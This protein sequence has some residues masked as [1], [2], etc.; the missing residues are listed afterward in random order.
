MNKKRQR[1]EIGGD[2]G[3]EEWGGYMNAKKSKLHGQFLEQ[4]KKQGQEHS[5]TTDIFKGVSVFVNG[6]TV[7]SADE[8]KRIMMVNGG[9]YHHYFSTQHTTHIIAS[10]LPDVKIKQLKNLHINIVKPEW[11]TA[12][13]NASLQVD[14]RPYLLY[15]HQSKTQPSIRSFAGPA[16]ST[17]TSKDHEL[18]IELGGH[19]TVQQ[20]E[21]SAMLENSNCKADDAGYDSEDLF[22]SPE[23][24]RANKSTVT[25]LSERDPKA[26]SSDSRANK[27]TETELSERDPK[28]ETSKSN[29]NARCAT[30]PN[31]L[32]EFYNN[33][34]LHHISTMGAMFKQFVLELRQK[35]SEFSG[36]KRLRDWKKTNSCRKPTTFEEE[37]DFEDCLEDN[38]FKPAA[39]V[40]GKIIMH[41]DMDCFFVSVGLRRY[42]HLKGKPVAVTHSKGNGAI[43][44]TGSDRKSEF[45][46][47]KER[48][49]SKLKNK[50][51]LDDDGALQ[52]RVAWMNGIDEN[53]SMAEIA[54]CSYEARQKGLKNGMFVGAAL[55]L[56]PDLKV[57]PYDFD[58]YNE[59]AKSLYN[60]VASYT[61]D[62]EAVSCDEMFVDC[63]EVLRKTE[64]TPIEF[65]AFLRREIKEKTQCT[66]STGFGSNRLLARL[67]TRKAKPDGMFHL[68]PSLAVEFMKAVEVKDLPGVGRTMTS[69]LHSKGVFTCGDLQN[70]PKA[71]VTELGD[72][73]GAL[74][75]KLCRGQDD[76]PLNFEHQRK[77]VSA[78]VN[79]GI[80]FKTEKEADAF[81]HQLSGEVQTRLSEAKVKGSCITLK[82]LIRAKNAPTETAKFMGHGVCDNIT[83]SSTLS[84]PVCDA[85]TIAGEVLQMMKKL[86]VNPCDLRGIGIQISR[87]ESLISTSSGGL[88]KFIL[89]NVSNPIS[90]SPPKLTDQPTTSKENST[91]SKIS[92]RKSKMLAVKG[93]VGIDKFM[94]AKKK[95]TRKDDVT[96]LPPAN[97]LDLEVLEALPDD[98]RNEVL[99]AYSSDTKNGVSHGS[100]SS[101]HTN[102]VKVGKTSELHGNT[103]LCANMDVS[104]SQVDPTFLEALP[105]DMRKELENDFRL[106]K[107]QKE[108][109]KKLKLIAHLDDAKPGPSHA[110]EIPYCYRKKSILGAFISKSTDVKNI[111]REWVSFETEPQPCDVHILEHYLCDL[112]HEKNIDDLFIIFKFFR[113]CVS[114]Q[115][116]SAWK[117]KFHDILHTVQTNMQHVYHSNLQV[118]DF[119]ESS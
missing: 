58:G 15:S 39:S 36:L 50:S 83:R 97:D 117:R 22:A 89:K 108:K 78:E 38:N 3:F 79:Y 91:L 55:K 105:S 41:I 95:T 24:I 30:D 31:F 87:L 99:E 46:L 25:E 54:S 49:E 27:S 5:D 65:G 62:I 103:S 59:V 42:P 107:D 96:K 70:L 84:R 114:M 109:E 47:Y 75:Y 101:I 72:K 86:N 110:Y 28:A 113:R 6:Y 66:A 52:D 51:N 90:K 19:D 43:A 61:T 14:F 82:L 60:T 1:A 26:E 104:Y 77:S 4:A 16:A 85:D 73:T 37:D 32:S 63:T 45:N 21:D 112:V 118:E 40:N 53:D 98:I 11:I 7:P 12:C 48:L 93:I 34:R 9:V 92:P 18:P 44:H 116:S 33:S 64:C 29:N 67:A 80:R 76:R 2:N 68:E 100:S 8:I 56:C 71:E 119:E 111:I 94:K 106:R 74:L 88:D 17:S 23:D 81:I 13:L 69:R 20:D 115:S 35:K 102:N 10:N 57:I